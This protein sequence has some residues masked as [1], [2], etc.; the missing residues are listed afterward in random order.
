MKPPSP[1]QH[2]NA[3]AGISVGSVTSL[4]VF[5]AKS[6]LGVDL[7]VEE[8]GMIVSGIIGLYLFFGKKV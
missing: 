5:E 4:L 1:A 6:R 3:Y 8:A 7:T 2:P